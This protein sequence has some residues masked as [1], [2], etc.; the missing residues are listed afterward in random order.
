MEYKNVNELI[1]K[2]GFED[3]KWIEGKEI[4]VSQW[5]RFI[6]NF[7]CDYYGTNAVCPPNVPTIDEC[8]RF[9]TEYSSAVIIHLEKPYNPEK[10]SSEIFEK[11]DKNLLEL[12]KEIFLN[13]FYKVLV[14]PAT[15]CYLCKHCPDERSNCHFK[16]KARPTPEALG[17]DVFETVKK[18][19]YPVEVLTDRSEI[20]NRYAI[21]MIN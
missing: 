7:S 8:R 10:T 19:G 2:Y 4:V 5:V 18:I 15:I 9:F 21:L 14:F 16:T 13:G 1:K 3:F 6:C 12:E 20:Q 11:I 17:V